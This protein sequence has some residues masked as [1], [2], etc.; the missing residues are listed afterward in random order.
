[1][2]IQ[3]NALG[4]S[5][6]SSNGGASAPAT[7]WLLGG[8]GVVVGFPLLSAVALQTIDSGRAAVILGLLPAVTAIFAQLT[9]GEGSYTP[10]PPVLFGMF[11]IA[12]V[13]QLL[14]FFAWYGGLARG[15]IGR[16]GQIQQVQPIL[17]I[18]WSAFLLGEPLGPETY[19]VGI[20]IAGFVWLAQRVRTA[21]G[22]RN[23][24]RLGEGERVL[25]TM[26]RWR[27]RSS[28]DL[29]R[30]APSRT[31]RSTSGREP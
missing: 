14:G 2:L 23:R 28:Q 13:S 11:Y 30:S 19:L 3:S 7:A 10:T 29:D 12:V 5:T 22:A 6:V 25:V 27:S 16:I 1:M 24:M 15:G 17:T 20:V 18:V 21:G 4:Q 8:L 26:T 31:P 9:G